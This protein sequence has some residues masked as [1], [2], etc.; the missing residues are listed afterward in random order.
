MNYIDYRMSLDIF[1]TVSQATLPVK[2]GDTAYRLCITLSANGSPY[3]ITD[4]CYALFTAKKPDGN[5]INN[6]CTIENNT[7]YYHLTPQTTAA[8]G[9]VECEI[10]LYDANDE[11]LATP[12]FNI[13]V[14]AKAYNGEEIKS[15]SEVNMLEDLIAAS[16]AQIAE[17]EEK[18]ANGEFK[19][20]KGDAG[21]IKFIPVTELP[22]ENIDETAVYTIPAQNPT[23]DN[24]YDEFS[25]NN[26]TW[27]RWGGGNIQADL[28]DYVKKTDYAIN[29]EAGV[30]KTPASGNYGLEVVAAENWAKGC[31]K[32]V[33]ATK[34][35]LDSARLTPQ[36]HSY[37]PITY[38][39]LDYA[40][41]LALTD[42]LLHEWTDEQKAAAR[43]LLGID[44]DECLK[45]TN[46]KQV[47]YGTNAN[48]E[49]TFYTIKSSAQA[50]SIALR[51][52]GGALNVGTPTADA[53]AATKQYVDERTKLCC[54]VSVG[55][56][57]YTDLYFPISIDTT[58]AY[59][60]SIIQNDSNNIKFSTEYS[61]YTFT[62]GVNTLNNGD[63]AHLD[64]TVN[65]TEK[66]EGWI[67][68][69]PTFNEIQGLTFTISEV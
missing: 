23:E 32:L 67:K 20:E 50:N 8:L 64:I 30:F 25:Y 60:I 2:Q 58:K 19:G 11:Q 41:M 18:L 5:F 12:H 27:E 14:D 53:H 61:S 31:V 59:N 51:E 10:V 17:V 21:T 35:R 42:P 45:E 33:T 57:S 22:T 43:T 40:V 56:G 9:M 46:N 66:G 49:Q 7:I 13:L 47:I 69:T 26:G 63:Y 65:P 24:K 15:S 36:N 68:I 52:A 4:K 29:G 16:E 39:A 28:N 55:L 6:K 48:G 44:L 62:S 54:S 34:A 1:K 3:I 38:N 37:Y